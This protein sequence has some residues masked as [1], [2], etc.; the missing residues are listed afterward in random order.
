MSITNSAK[1]TRAAADVNV[2]ATTEVDI[3]DNTILD[4]DS[5]LHNYRLFLAIY[6]KGVQTDGITPSTADVVIKYPGDD[7]AESM[8]IIS[9]AA[10]QTDPFILSG[11]PLP[12]D[13]KFYTTGVGGVQLRVET[14]VMYAGSSRITG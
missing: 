3:F 14:T 1:G 4:P 6:H 2:A 12:T 8:M 7:E 11:E 9:T 13:L 10:T 5:K